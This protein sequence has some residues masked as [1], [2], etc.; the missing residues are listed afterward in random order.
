MVWR[1]GPDFEGDMNR[2]I[3]RWYMQVVGGKVHGRLALTYE[4][5]RLTLN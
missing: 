5:T 3:P 2:W 1:H 4:I